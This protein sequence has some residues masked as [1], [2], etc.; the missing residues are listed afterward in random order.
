MD[1]ITTAK[2]N[3]LAW[4][5]NQGVALNGDAS[6]EEVLSALVRFSENSAGERSAPTQAQ[7]ASLNRQLKHERSVT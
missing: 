4:L 1:S 5:K 2:R 3:T 7:V 6:D